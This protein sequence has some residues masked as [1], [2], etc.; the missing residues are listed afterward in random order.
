MPEGWPANAIMS[1]VTAR[2]A[3]AAAV[4]I[5]LGVAAAVG[6]ARAR[7]RNDGQHDNTA[8]TPNDS[9]PIEPNS[10]VRTVPHAADS[11]RQPTYPYEQLPAV[12]FHNRNSQQTLTAKLYHQAGEIDESAAVRIDEV[13]ADMRDP[14]RPK[15]TP[16]DRRLLQL[17]YRT[18]YHFN[19]PSI[20][21]TSAFRMPGRKREGL[22]ALGRAI[23]FAIVGVKTEE[24]ASY[25]RK[26]P[27]VGVGLYTHRR[28]RFVHLDVREQSY[29]W[30]D[31]SPPGRTWRGMSLGD[32]GLVARDA[33]YR[34]VDDWPE[35]APTAA[36]P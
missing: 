2:T 9:A 33:G 11:A 32:N 29:H 17:L 7:L 27:R 31:A 35:V 23:D 30:L 13:L 18:A 36:N 4:V 34:T 6:A 3:L 5:A 22:H 20:E 16:I 10:E 26:L 12:T 14:K 28:T 19:A 1:T 21:V 25:L 8:E 15:T 24:L